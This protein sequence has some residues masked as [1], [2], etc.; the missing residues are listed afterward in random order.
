M[1]IGGEG[2]PV[3]LAEFVADRKQRLGC[4]H[5]FSDDHRGVE[6]EA[7]FAMIVCMLILIDTGEKPNRAMDQMIWHELIGLVGQC[8]SLPCSRAFV[9]TLVGRGWPCPRAA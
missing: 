5:L 7:S 9:D 6:I 3:P 2:L 4:R 1:S 8:G